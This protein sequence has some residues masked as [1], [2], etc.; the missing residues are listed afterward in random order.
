MSTSGDTE[1]LQSTSGLSQKWHLLL[2]FLGSDYPERNGA[3][4]PP[5][6]GRPCVRSTIGLG[7]LEV[8]SVCKWL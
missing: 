4:P 1:A 2:I 3:C 8:V 5:A 7:H 6:S